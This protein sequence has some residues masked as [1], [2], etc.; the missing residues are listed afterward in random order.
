MQDK[1]KDSTTHLATRFCDEIS[2]QSL[3]GSIDICSGK[4]LDIY[5]TFARPSSSVAL[6]IALRAAGLVLCGAALVS[7]FA[8]GKHDALFQLAFLSNWILILS[9]M[10]FALALSVAC[11]PKLTAITQERTHTPI[12]VCF[13]WAL[14]TV[15]MS[16][17]LVVTMIFWPFYLSRD[18]NGSA[19]TL[20]HAIIGHGVVFLLLLVDGQVCSCIPI[21]LKHFWF[22]FGLSVV[23]SC[24]AIVHSQTGIGNPFFAD[25]NSIYP[26]QD[27][28]DE[29]VLMA[30]KTL[31]V[32]CIVLPLAFV[33]FWF[34]SLWS[35]PWTFQGERWCV[36]PEEP[37]PGSSDEESA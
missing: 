17:G 33:L 4:Q 22:A 5:T 30:L 2:R 11:F 15:T 27:W 9:M 26:D 32:L 25:Q 18:V 36:K 8:A 3:F 6:T 29:P 13:T 28:N 19:D 31:G 12:I 23:Y 20:E 7:T 37:S 14:Y 21:R 24:W 1:E 10:Y 16:C 35:R 34:G